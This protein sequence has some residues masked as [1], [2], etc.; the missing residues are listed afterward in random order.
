MF[1]RITSPLYRRTGSALAVLALVFGMTVALPNP[2]TATPDAESGAVATATAEATSIETV[3]PATEAEAPGELGA[4]GETQTVELGDGNVQYGLRL[5]RDGGAGCIITKANGYEPGDNTPRD[6][7]ICAGD[8]AHYSIDL[9]VKTA[10]EP[11]TFKLTPTW[12]SAEA[13]AAGLPEPTVKPTLKTGSANYGGVSATVDANG[14]VTVKADPN[15]NATV[16]LELTASTIA[17]MQLSDGTNPEGTFN[18]GLKAVKEDGTKL[19]TAVANKKLNV[20]VEPRF[21]QRLI[22]PESG[23]NTTTRNGIEYI[24]IS[25]RSGLPAYPSDQKH[26]PAPDSATP[27]GRIL[28]IDPETISRYTLVMPADAPFKAEDV[29]VSYNGSPWQKAKVD[30]NGNP[31]IDG[32]YDKSNPPFRFLIPTEGLPGGK[33]TFTTRMDIVD[34]DGKP[35]RVKDSRGVPSNIP[36]TVGNKALGNNTADPGGLSECSASTADEKQGLLAG[37]YGFPNNNCAKQVVDL[38]KW[39]CTNPNG[40]P[41]AKDDVGINWVE[42]EEKGKQAFGYKQALASAN[43][44]LN[45]TPADV[46]DNPT[47][48]AAWKP[49]TQRVVTT[50]NTYVP[51][52]QIG[53]TGKVNIESVFPDAKVYITKQ[54]KTNGGDPDCAGDAGWEVFYDASAG[55]KGNTFAEPGSMKPNE[56]AGIKIVIPG[57][58]VIQQPTTFRYMATT[59]DPRV[60]STLPTVKAAKG[61]AEYYK[62]L[63]YG[64]V[65]SGD[66]KVRGS[67]QDTILAEKPAA[68]VRDIWGTL[69]E[70]RV[71]GIGE[72]KQRLTT[73]GQVVVNNG[74]LAAVNSK[75]ADG[76]PT[77]VHMRIYLSKCVTADEET[78]SPGM[79]YHRGEISNNPNDCA[80][81][82]DNYIERTW[83]LSDQKNETDDPN[84]DPFF[85]ID[86]ATKNAASSS[87]FFQPWDNGQPRPAFTVVTP[88]WSGPRQS[89]DV[90]HSYRITGTPELDLDKAMPA[91]KKDRTIKSSSSK[92]A[93]TPAQDAAKE[94]TPLDSMASLS[95]LTVPNVVAAGLAKSTEDKLVD[96][97]TAFQHELKLSNYTEAQLGATQ[98]IDVLP[99]NGD[100]RGTKFS[101]EYWLSKVPENSGSNTAEGHEIYYTYDDPNTVSVC[102]TN[103]QGKDDLDACVNA[104]RATKRDIDK[105]PSETKWELLTQEVIEAQAQ[106]GAKHITA[107]R[108]DSPLLSPKSEDAYVLDFESYGNKH[109]DK[110]VNSTGIATMHAVRGE[111]ADTTGVGALPVPQPDPVKTEVY[112]PKIS[113]TVYHDANRDEKQ[114]DGEKNLPGYTVTLYEV[115]ENG[116]I[117]KDENGEPVAVQTT[118]SDKDGNY[119]FESL[120]RGDYRVVVSPLEETDINTQ[121]G[122]GENTDAGSWTG[123]VITVTEPNPDKYDANKPQT[124]SKYDFGVFKPAPKISLKKTVN[125]KD[126]DEVAVNGEA[127]FALAGENNGNV[128]LEKV[129]LVDTWAEGKDPLDLTCTITP[130][131][132]SDYAGDATEDLLNGEAKLAVGDTYECIG[133][134]TVTQDDVDE[135][136]TLPNNADVTGA[137]LYKSATTDEDK[138]LP[139]ED[140]SKATVTVPEAKP[141]LEVTKTVDGQKSVM[142]KAGEK[143]EWSITGKNTGNVTLYNVKLADEWAGGDI[144]LTCTMGEEEIDVAS[145]DVTLPVGAEF[146]CTGESEITQDHVD[147]GNELPNTVTLTGSSKPEGGEKVSSKDTAT[148]TVPKSEPSLSLQKTVTNWAEDAEPAPEPLTVGDKV[149]Y[150]F[151]VSNNGNVTVKD[152]TVEDPKVQDLDCG[153]ANT[154]LA[155]GESFTC[156]ASHV[157]T[158]E[159]VEGQT[160]YVNTA[161]ANG[162]TVPGEPVES[163]DAEAKVKVATPKL[164]LEKTVKDKKDSYLAG[165]KVEYLFTVTNT[166]KLT[167]NGIELDD[168]MLTEADVDVTCEAETLAPGES[169][170][171]VSGEYTVTEADADAGEVINT[172]TASGTTNNGTPVKSNEANAKIT[173]EKPREPEEPSEPAPSESP[174]PSEPAPSEPAPSDPTP[175]EPAPSEPGDPSEPAPEE[176]GES[177]QPSETPE[178]SETPAPETPEGRKPGLAT[179]GAEVTVAVLAGLGL[180]AAGVALVLVRRKRRS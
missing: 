45:V 58:N 155:P 74:T 12:L 143:A 63:N 51:T 50:G 30:A 123:Q 17:S 120:K 127:K 69:G 84:N 165:D 147:A 91:L 133:T 134:Y 132:G 108:F 5:A 167:V 121:A 29:L 28:P 66:K 171:C 157:L 99:F 115:D 122:K 13:R 86:W 2:A 102:P 135:Q 26:S 72:Q 55:V 116:E 130:K 126:S 68:G 65:Y 95:T 169:T 152:V 105:K 109:G 56:I 151:I 124:H 8:I 85:P 47:I 53:G 158:K 70:T 64:A 20:L 162:S 34:K 61:D 46:K 177:P 110:Y 179:T 97:D 172:A 131:T 138:E 36:T 77:R 32:K 14:V 96:H 168:A 163:N 160:E 21:D 178:A 137:Y 180:V 142:K 93:F 62:T 111:T 27:N 104:S 75:D 9:N 128:D 153:E 136:V 174:E 83:A 117:K 38:T 76:N 16:S 60:V 24:G 119:T 89:F 7:N 3:A 154:T 144:E 103:A 94:Y 10:G 140:H 37:Q 87:V 78:L 15:I 125:G 11:S 159:D 79:T 81:S 43:V 141:A 1:T 170:M 166:G 54:D 173:V 101:G 49:G 44:R 100:W 25:A 22:E 156:T 148:V 92:G 114:Q 149:E 73:A 6:G 23:V 82:K 107:L 139:V 150:S 106:P 88:V 41:S 98:F 39:K 19:I 35:T 67:M 42:T 176:P 59:G 129:K 33:T 118:T 90:V 145:G 18:L 175:S 113:G 57:E 40:C 164:E 161:K 146:T 71:A 31:Y 112:A 4:P 52:I 80:P 48:C